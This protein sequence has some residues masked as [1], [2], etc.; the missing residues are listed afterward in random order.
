MGILKDLKTYSEIYYD[1]WIPAS[2]ASLIKHEIG[3]RGRCAHV[4]ELACG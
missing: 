4:N 1:A 2:V 3:K